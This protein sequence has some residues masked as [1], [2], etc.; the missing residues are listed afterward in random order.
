MADGSSCHCCSGRHSSS[1]VQSLS[2][3]AFSRS[4]AGAAQAGDVARM[5]SLL[6]KGANPDGSSEDGYTPLHFAA[7]SGHLQACRLLLQYGASADRR[8][9]AGS[10]TSLHR[11]AYA[12]HEEV[13]LLLLEH[14]ANPS[15]VDADGSTPIDKAGK[16]GHLSLESLLHRIASG[17]FENGTGLFS[18]YA[19]SVEVFVNDLRN[20]HSSID[21][22]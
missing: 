19:D 10:A 22:V 12:G 15:A 4:L 21:A 18:N 6:E 2:E 7:R 8:T 1:A 20:P 16:Q 5:K 11:A 13:A 14:G 9:R 17:K 3:V